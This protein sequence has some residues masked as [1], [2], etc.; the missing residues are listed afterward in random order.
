[1][2]STDNVAIFCQSSFW[3]RGFVKNIKGMTKMYH[4]KRCYFKLKN[5]KKG[6][7]IL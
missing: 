6:G 7:S 3:P 1:M 5:Q 2:S 4:S